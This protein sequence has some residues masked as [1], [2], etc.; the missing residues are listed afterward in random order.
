MVFRRSFEELAQHFR[1]LAPDL[2]GH[3][4][5]QNPT[6]AGYTAIAGTR[7]LAAFLEQVAGEPAH[8]LGV[9]AGGLLSGLV[10]YY[11]PQ[12]VR[13]LVLV[14]SAGLGRDLHW[15][16]R[17]ASMPSLGRL[18]IPRTRRGVRAVLKMVIHDP[19]KVDNELVEQ[20]YQERRL[21]GNQEALYWAFR[22]GVGPLGQ[23][24]WQ[25]YRRRILRLSL[26]VLLAW[27]AQDRVIPVAHALAAVRRMANARLHVFGRCGHWPF[28]EY[29]E[30]F[31]RLVLSFLLSFPGGD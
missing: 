21:A 18:F 3:G 19:S 6:K 30:E 23:L 1:V 29:P 8:L 4:R 14:G 11:Y 26:P 16:L 31:N 24:S 12:R 22:S 17:L 13:R 27:G 28:Y 5:S 20:L 15:S 9:S 2:P 10:A 7:F 25:A